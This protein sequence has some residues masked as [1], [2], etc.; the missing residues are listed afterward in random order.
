MLHNLSRLFDVSEFDANTPLTLRLDT[1]FEIE[2]EEREGE[3]VQRDEPEGNGGELEGRE[4]EAQAHRGGI[5]AQAARFEDFRW[6]NVAL[7]RKQW[8]SRGQTSIH[9]SL[10]GSGDPVELPASDRSF[11]ARL[12]R[13]HAGGQVGK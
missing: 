8:V 9:I 3:T 12:L 10:H 2:A 5:K 6:M 13:C 7:D 1:W 11:Q 4:H